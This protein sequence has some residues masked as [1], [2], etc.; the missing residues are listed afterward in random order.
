MNSKMKFGFSVSLLGFLA[1]LFF[2]LLFDTSVST[3]AGFR[4]N[5]LG[6]MQ[7]RQNGMMFSI[8]FFAVGIFMVFSA[9]K[10]EK[11]SLSK[12]ASD[13]PGSKSTSSGFVGAKELSNDSYK[14]YLVKKFEIEKNSLLEKFSC[15]GEVFD[16]LELALD[17]AFKLDSNRPK[18]LVHVVKQSMLLGFKSYSFFINGVEACQPLLMDES[19]SIEVDTGDLIVQA[20]M[21]IAVGN[22]FSSITE[23]LK[24]NLDSGQLKKIDVVYNRTSGKTELKLVD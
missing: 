19:K 12:I 16:N 8:V 17:Y 1:F 22:I 14:I 5:N 13:N 3:G 4:V 21:N 7:D 9:N 11:E 10:D 23:P 6:L 2:F 24:V 20:K 18:I 15:R